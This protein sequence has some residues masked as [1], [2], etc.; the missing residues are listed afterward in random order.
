MLSKSSEYAIRAMVSIQLQNWESKRP[1]VSDVANHIEA[2]IAF[3][4]K[5]L[6]VLTKAGLLHSAKG[7]G[8]GFFFS[9]DDENEK[10]TLFQ[11]VKVIEGEGVFHRCGF[12]MKNCSDENPCPLHHQYKEVRDGFGNIVK[13]ATVGSLAEKIRDGEAAMN[14]IT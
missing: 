13:N 9:D 11:I 10:V 8:G 3:T 1:G 7:R 4:A 12:G 14:S 6:Q 2:P 5:I